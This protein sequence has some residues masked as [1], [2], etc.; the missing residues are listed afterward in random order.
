MKGKDLLEGFKEFLIC[1]DNSKNTIE[2]YLRSTGQLLNHINKDVNGISQKD[3]NAY[4]IYLKERYS[5]NTLT[6]KI[7]A[8]NSFMEYLGKNLKLSAPA[9]EVKNKNP[10]TINEVKRMFEVS[11]D[12]PEDYAILNVLYYGQL[13]RDEVL[14]LNLEDI[15]WE[16]EKIRVNKGKG[17]RY[18]IINI[19]PAALQTIKNY[20]SHRIQPRE[21]H[22][23]AL[24]INRYHTRIGRTAIHNSVKRTAAKAGIKKRTYPHLF[25]ISS[26]THMAE[27]GATMPEIQKQSRHRDLDTLQG[28][29][30]LADEHAKQVYMKTM[31]SFTQEIREKKDDDENMR[32]KLLKRLLNG[33][34]SDIAFNN[35]MKLL[36]SEK[37]QFPTD[38]GYHY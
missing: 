18:D 7:A 25:R 15:D 11:K 10:L 26:I 6:P 19:H 38:T 23:K 5:H 28:Y 34:I 37:R 16:R 29:I 13:R 22:E 20:L 1:R 21:E 8:V 14:N 12:D 24:F 31:P 32:D 17:N 2:S 30:Q 3:L 33:D 9:K 27:R 36:E 35:A 4:K